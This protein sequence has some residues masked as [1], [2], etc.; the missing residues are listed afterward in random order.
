MKKTQIIAAYKATAGKSFDK[1][2]AFE[3]QGWCQTYELFLESGLDT[4]EFG[5]VLEDAG[6]NKVATVKQNLSHIKWAI[7]YLSETMEDEATIADVV[8]EFTNILAIRKLRY[9]NKT[10]EKTEKKKTSKSDEFDAK[11]S[12]KKFTVNQLLAML[13]A[14]GVK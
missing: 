7:A 6:L 3:L 10:E 14:K 12:A 9:P 4:V 5:Q 8:V 11:A 2:K 1:A 13:A